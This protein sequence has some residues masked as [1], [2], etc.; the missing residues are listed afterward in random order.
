MP[1]LAALAA[2][3]LLPAAAAAAGAGAAA[4]DPLFSA[5]S[6]LT[7]LH[8]GVVNATAGDAFVYSPT[9]CSYLEPEN[10]TVAP[11]QGIGWT[12]GGSCPLLW[13]ANASAGPAPPCNATAPHAG[14]DRQ[15]GDYRS[16]P[17]PTGGTPACEAACCGEAQCVAWAFTPT[18]P[19]GQVPCAAGTPCCYLKAAVNPESPDANVTN[20]VVVRPPLAL[21]PPPVGMRSAVPLGGVGAGA[22]E[23]RADGTFHE[24]TIVNQSPA[25]AAKFGV[26]ADAWL[27]VR[28]GGVA[29]VL[30]T[31]PPPF[32][33]GAGAGGV[34]SL[35]Y[36]GAYPAAR[37]APAAAD[38]PVPV[39]LYA[40]SKLVPGDPAASA[41]PAIVFT[42][43]ASNPTPAAVN[44]SLV[45]VSPLA[46]VADCARPSAAP[47][48]ANLTTATAA[49][50]LHACA[51]APACASWTWSGAGGGGGGGGGACRLAPDVPLSVYVAGA[52]CGVAGSW[53]S[54]GAR[55]AGGVTLTLPCAAAAPSPACGDT[56]V[57]PVAAAGVDASAG[58][59]DDPA[60]LWASFAAAGR[61]D[62]GAPGVTGGSF[63]GAPAAL[64]AAA[65]TVTVPP[66][67][68]ATVSVVWSWYFPHRDHAGEDIGNFYSTL[69]SSSVDAAASVAGGDGGGLVA[70]VTDLA[71]HH[72]VFLGAGS[73]LPDWLADML[74]NQMSHFRG[75]IWSRDGRMR[76]FEAF[77][78][79][80]LDSIH[81]D[82][83]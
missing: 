61:I 60:A 27:G 17:L 52:A 63:F 68:N 9:P 12:E 2:A 26:L 34:S 21:A 80:D 7:F 53:A 73:S 67:G 19:P 29:R 44:L 57:V 76:E 75:M 42:A 37:L 71:A 4:A 66:G 64:G 30:R 47:P 69:W 23:L 43:A 6:R 65:A 83:G 14:Y 15:G 46:A 13:A 59:A 8:E 39:A 25:G 81:N 1:A 78:C 58:V 5:L 11:A 41:A 50:C 74:I 38:F 28:A 22:V 62:A 49:A 56:S 48:V 31:A 54:L 18:A 32:A 20:G 40:Y 45:F 24:A 10:V 51:A 55:G 35:A 36:S 82:C 77:D 79:C 70:T 33:A 3:A 16:F 72:A